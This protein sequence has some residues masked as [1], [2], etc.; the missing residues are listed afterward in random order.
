MMKW[1]LLFLAGG[2]GTLA[3][4]CFAGVAS[5]ILGSRFPYGT[6][7]INLLGCFFI[8]FLVA[9]TQEKLLISE[10]LKLF[11]MVGFIGA[12]TTFSTFIFETSGLLKNG[13]F[14]AAFFN[15]IVSLIIGFLF[16]E[17]GFWLGEIV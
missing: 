16:F 15:V 11:L 4:Y 10:N 17:V 5:Q 9:L 3:R 1:A 2:V 13:Q 7:M 12:F 6:L 14:A 8:G